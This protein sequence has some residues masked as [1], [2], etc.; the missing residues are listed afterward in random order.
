[1]SRVKF[2]VDWDVKH[3]TKQKTQ[4]HGTR[5]NLSPLYIVNPETGTLANSEDQVDEILQNIAFCQDLQ[6]LS[7]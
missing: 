4:L 6:C 1:M 5:P 7:K 3:E 2:C